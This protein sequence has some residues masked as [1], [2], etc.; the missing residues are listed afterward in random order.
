MIMAKKK[1]SKKDV[2]HLA[3]LS[4][5]KLTDKELEKYEKQLSETLDYIENLNELDTENVKEA[6]SVIDS[7]D[8]FF[9]DGEENERGL[10]EKET[11]STTNKTKN[12][13]FVVE[14][15]L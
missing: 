4:A 15:I 8:V 13:Q 2:Q 9:E 5:L 7:K 6:H 3:N 1:L 10:S 14:R 11:F 12:N